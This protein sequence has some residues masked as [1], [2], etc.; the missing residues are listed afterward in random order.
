MS[1]PQKH[2][3]TEIAVL[4]AKNLLKLSL[5]VTGAQLAYC[6]A[7]VREI[8]LIYYMPVKYIYTS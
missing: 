8:E 5:G 7:R 2:V 6:S 3:C 4:N 1:S